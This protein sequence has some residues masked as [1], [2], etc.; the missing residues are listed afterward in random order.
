MVAEGHQV[1]VFGKIRGSYAVGNDDEEV[2]E[3]IDLFELGKDGKVK[4]HRDVQQNAPV[5]V[6]EL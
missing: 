3:S 2:R 1:W 6:P 5:K 4:A